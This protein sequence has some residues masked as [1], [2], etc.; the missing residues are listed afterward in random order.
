MNK[1]YKVIWSKVKHQ[2]VVVSE[3]A[4]SNGK[5][6]RTS[7]NSIRS[8]IAALVV[9]G[10]I[11]AFGVFSALPMDSAYAADVNVQQAT[12]TQY[13]A[14]RA[15]TTSDEW[16]KGEKTIEGIVFRPQTIRLSDKTLN[17]WVREGYTL[18]ATEGIQYIPDNLMKTDDVNGHKSDYAISA[19]ITDQN[20]IK[21]SVLKTTE[22]SAVGTTAMTTRNESLQKIEVG[23]YTG[24]SNSGGVGTGTI[25]WNYIIDPNGQGNVN[26]F[27]DIKDAAPDQWDPSQ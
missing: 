18:K 20:L 11:A 17:Y 4:H 14:F 16:R 12:Q 5:Q 8:R 13:V 3:L 9:C 26:E 27:I 2:Y 1:I 22:S 7:R 6:S 15:D 21:G 25:D 23:H 24:V 19:E 10:A